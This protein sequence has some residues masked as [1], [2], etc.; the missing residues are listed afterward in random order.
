MCSSYL[1]W[2]YVTDTRDVMLGIGANNKRL[3]IF[4]ETKSSCASVFTG[5]TKL[6]CLSSVLLRQLRT[7]RSSE[8]NKVEVG[9]VFSLLFF[10]SYS[11]RDKSVNNME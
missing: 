1:L 9:S 2:S 7:E 4:E 6:R 11:I 5:K 10:Y 3:A 8:Q